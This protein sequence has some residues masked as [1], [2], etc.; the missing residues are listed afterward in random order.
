MRRADIEHHLASAL[1]W[2]AVPLVA[3]GVLMKALGA[4]L[5]LLPSPL[6][7]AASHLRLGWVRRH[8]RRMRQTYGGY[9]Q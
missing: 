8:N 3:A 6:F 2:A 9:R 5:I 4:T 1:E 7:D